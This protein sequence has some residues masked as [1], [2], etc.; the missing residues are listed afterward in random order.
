METEEG[1]SQKSIKVSTGLL[2]ENMQCAEL[3]PD[4]QPRP[5]DQRLGKELVKPIVGLGILGLTGMEGPL[6]SDL[7]KSH[8]P[9]RY[10]SWPSD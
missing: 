6:L 2:G 5:D 4:L 8:R 1:F 10:P 9:L 7:R 3:V